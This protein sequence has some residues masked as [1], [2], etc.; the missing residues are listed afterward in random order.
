M[1]NSQ[2]QKIKEL[3]N[4]LPDMSF[5]IFKDGVIILN[6]QTKKGV[7]ISPTDLSLPL[8]ILVRHVISNTHL[9]N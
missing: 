8:E 6:Y 2:L 5:E 9:I 3:E 4:K 1:T 7:K